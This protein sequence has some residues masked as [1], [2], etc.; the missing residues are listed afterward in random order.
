MTRTHTVEIPIP[1]T[2]SA[3]QAVAVLDV[4]EELHAAIWDLYEGPVVDLI[5]QQQRRETS[6]DDDSAWPP[7]SSA[8]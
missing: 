7:R 2:W 6:P 3:D 8:R 1:S 4:L 5:E